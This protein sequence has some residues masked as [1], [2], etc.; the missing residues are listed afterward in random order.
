MHKVITS[1]QEERYKAKPQSKRVVTTLG[2]H[3]DHKQHLSPYKIL[4]DRFYN[5]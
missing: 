1:T 5:E 2:D 3:K 4:K